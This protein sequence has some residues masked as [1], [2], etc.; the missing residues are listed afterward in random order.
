MQD[1]KKPNP[2]DLPDSLSMITLAE[3]VSP[4]A[5]NNSFKS[6]SFMPKLKPEM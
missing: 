5:E 6:A 4:Y 3:E 2:L 1:I